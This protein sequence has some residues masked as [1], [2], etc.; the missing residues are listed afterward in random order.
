M[1]FKFYF[2]E[3]SRFSEKPKNIDDISNNHH[4]NQQEKEYS[5]NFTILTHR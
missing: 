5:S 1:R 2:M 3:E 4:W